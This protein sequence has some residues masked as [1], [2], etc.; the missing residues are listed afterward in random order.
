MQVSTAQVSSDLV[1]TVSLANRDIKSF[2]TY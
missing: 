2:M 1:V